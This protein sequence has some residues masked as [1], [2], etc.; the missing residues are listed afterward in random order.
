MSGR[1]QRS[2]C[3]RRK[4]L[5]KKGPERGPRPDNAPVVC[6][7]RFFNWGGI[8]CALGML[9]RLQRSTCSRPDVSWFELV[10]PRAVCWGF[11]A[12]PLVHWLGRAT[13][14]IPQND[15][16]P[17]QPSLPSLIPVSLLAR[18]PTTQGAVPCFPLIGSCQG[19]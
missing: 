15:S 18:N 3:L 5:K 8:S 9:P 1:G 13:A 6:V 2:W 14:R 4:S 17:S 19:W 10:C 12:E 7:S 11:T 16:S